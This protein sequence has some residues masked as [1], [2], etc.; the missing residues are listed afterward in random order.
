MKNNK[1][2]QRILFIITILILSII[3]TIIDI[4]P[5]F[6]SAYDFGHS[7]G[8]MFKNMLKIS[9]VVFIS[10]FLFKKLKNK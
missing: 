9:V 1:T 3:F 6:E 8:V 4:Y 2:T 5:T 10:F 7:T